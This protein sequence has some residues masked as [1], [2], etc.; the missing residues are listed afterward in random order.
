MSRP[1]ATACSISIGLRLARETAMVGCTWRPRRCA[2]LAGPWGAACVG[3]ATA[4]ATARARAWARARVR[5]RV[6]VRVRL[7]V[8][9]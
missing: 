5:L 7:R 1:A 6:G 3:R 4:K 8:T 2:S 9:P